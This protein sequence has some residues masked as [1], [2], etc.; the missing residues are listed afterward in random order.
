MKTTGN[1]G[2]Y[3][4]RVILGVG[5]AA[6]GLL[7]SPALAAGQGQPQGQIT[8]AKDIAPIL[9]RTCQN[10]HRPNGGVAPMALTTYEEVR[11]WARAIKLRTSLREMPPWFIEKNVGIQKFKDDISLS[12]EEIAKIGTWVDSGAPQ[13]NP[14]DMP[15]PRQFADSN[16]WSIGTPDLIVSSPLITVKAEGS[17]FH[18]PYLGASPT[19]LTKDR[20]IAAIEAREFRPGEKKRSP[21]RPGGGNDY[22]VIH[23]QNIGSSPLNQREDGTPDRGVFTDYTYEVGQNALFFPADLGVKLPAGSSIHFNSSH[24]HS[25]GKEVKVHVQIAF[26]FHPEGYTPKFPQGLTRLRTGGL[27][28]ELDISGNQD[29]VRFDKIFAIDKPARMVNFEPHLHAS[30]KRMCVEAIYPNGTQEMLNCAGYNHAWVKSYSYDDDVAPLLP[31]GTI[32]HVIGWYDNTAKNPRV[33]DSR[34]WRGVGHRSVDDMLNLL[35]RMVVYTD[36]E[37]K[38]E[39]A[40]REAK[41]RLNKTTTTQNQQ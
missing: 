18:D 25:I 19:G 39:V 28:G 6:V 34:N 15:P 36:E 23:H 27:G 9:Q 24:Q 5:L 40:A 21:G 22:F 26:K 8:F 4:A 2:C 32:L 3:S 30:G 38:V 33:V 14:A 11:P 7:A 31:A 17:D 35:S 29:N 12:D 16:V 10:C 37:F 13:G 41:Q 20:W 1:P